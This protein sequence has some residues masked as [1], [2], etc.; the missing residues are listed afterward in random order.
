MILQFEY[1]LK[2]AHPLSLGI[3]S[4]C[5]IASAEIFNYNEDFIKKMNSCFPSGFYISDIQKI[6]KK[7]P[8]L[9]SMYGGSDFRI[10]GTNSRCIKDAIEQKSSVSEKELFS[11][12]NVKVLS[13]DSENLE[14]RILNTGRKDSNILKI[15]EY[16]T[17]NTETVYDIDILRTAAWAID[18]NGNLADYFDIMT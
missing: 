12:G 17:E 13:S 2:F 9:M 11:L 1:L 18:Q 16:C 14:L 7:H 5:E 4:T 3:F 10:C 15:I 6:S 8:S